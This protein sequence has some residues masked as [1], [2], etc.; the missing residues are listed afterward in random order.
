MAAA[1]RIVKDADGGVSLVGTVD[2]LTVVFAT[3][4]VSQLHE[5]RASQPVAVEE[6]AV[7]PVADDEEA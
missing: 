3:V 4:N 5:L 6:P 7:E 2:G 1:V